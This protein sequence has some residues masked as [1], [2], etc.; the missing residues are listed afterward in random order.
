[1]TL[2]SKKLIAPVLVCVL[3][4]L[5]LVGYLIGCILLPIPVLLK[6]IGAAAILALIGVS[7]F[8]LIERV[9]EI[10]SGETDDLSKY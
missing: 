9:Q 7:V 2:R 5:I 4:V 1:M 6:V 10:R 8:V 3:L